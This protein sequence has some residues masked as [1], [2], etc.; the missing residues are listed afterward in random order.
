MT[1]RRFRNAD[2]PREVDWRF[3]IVL[4]ASA[5]VAM[6]VGPDQEAECIRKKVE[7]LSESLYVPH[8]MDL[9][10]LHALRR[11]T[12]LGTP[13]QRRGAQALEDRKNIALVCYPHASL[14]DRI[15]GLK[16]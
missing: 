10:V 8:L 6:L 5:V 15:W 4:D 9:E 14:M 11:Q 7:G 3:V 2:D 1:I 13:S 16:E 12:L